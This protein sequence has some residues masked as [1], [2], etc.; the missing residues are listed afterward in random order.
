MAVIRLRSPR[1]IIVSLVTAL[2][3]VAVFVVIGSQSL[4]SV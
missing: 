3:V 2:T 4:A 1:P